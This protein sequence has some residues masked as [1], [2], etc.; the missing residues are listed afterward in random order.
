MMASFIAAD[1]RLGLRRLVRTPAS[2]LT[3]LTALSVGIGLSA[4]MFSLISSAVLPTL[5]FEAGERIVRVNRVDY[6]PISVAAYEYWGERQRSFEGMGGWIERPVNLAAGGESGEPVRSAA[7]EP[8]ALR[9][10]SVRPVLGRAFTEADAAP[11]AP[12][13]VLLGHGIWRTRMNGDPDVVG[14][15]VRVNGEPAEV[16]GVMPEDFGFPVFQDLWMP[17]RVDALRP[18]RHPGGV[19][20]FGVLR[21]GVSFEAASAELNALDRQRPRP[22]TEAEAPPL[23]VRAY[24]DIVNPAGQSQL[25]AATL[26]AV[27]LLVLLV[28]C[29]NATNVL[30]AQA[31][32]RAREVAV[33]SALGASRVRIATQFW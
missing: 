32:V 5:P 10:L 4:L 11:G 23:E 33:R 12:A 2:T 8:G 28:A 27:A 6:A 19:S 29:A 3:A 7:L 26:L 21:E 15:T 16:V 20:V 14:R 22:A 17:L 24:T 9:L 18:D 1:V 31:T 30:L 25:L 13:V